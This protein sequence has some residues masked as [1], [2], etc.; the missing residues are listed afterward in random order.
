[1]K[2]RLCYRGVN[3]ESYDSTILDAVFY[4]AETWATLHQL[5]SP[6]VVSNTYLHSHGWSLFVYFFFCY[7]V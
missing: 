4:I 7:T 3:E 2:E 6:F 1:M 5:Y